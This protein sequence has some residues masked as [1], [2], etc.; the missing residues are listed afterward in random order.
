MTYQARETKDQGVYRCDVCH[1]E[2]R[3][4]DAKSTGVEFL[5]MSTEEAVGFSGKRKKEVFQILNTE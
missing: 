4:S 1:C 2:F 5:R 3:Y